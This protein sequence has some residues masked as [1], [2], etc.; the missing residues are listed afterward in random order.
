MANVDTLKSCVSLQHILDFIKNEQKWMA[1]DLKGL[2][3]LHRRWFLSRW[4]S[5]IVSVGL[6]VGSVLTFF[7]VDVFTTGMH[8]NAIELMVLA[9]MIPGFFFL[10]SQNFKRQHMIGAD[11]QLSSS[12]PQCGIHVLDAFV[13]HFSQ[14]H[15]DISAGFVS[16]IHD[17]K[18]NGL[19]PYQAYRIVR[20][21]QLEFGITEEM[22]LNDILLPA[23]T[24]D[25]QI[26]LNPLQHSVPTRNTLKL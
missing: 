26:D 15:A 8:T 23:V 21:L 9:T 11:E 1:A 19:T 4:N 3:A 13:Q 18:A 16:Q 10:C 12:A 24:V 7:G 6:G 14:K 22:L 5:E 25:S 17:L 20:I 2:K